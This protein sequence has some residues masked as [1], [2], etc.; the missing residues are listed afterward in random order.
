MAWI[1]DTYSM[2]KG[3]SVLG[4]VTGKPLNVGG[5]LGR[6][7][8]TARGALYCIREAVRKKELPLAGPDASP[9]RASATSAASS[10]SS[11]PRRAR[12]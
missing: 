1:F 5:S 3:H 9:C 4:V 7:E 6:H 12:R 8:A 11:S 2:N 10:R